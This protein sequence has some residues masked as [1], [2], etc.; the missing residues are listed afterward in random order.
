MDF[1]VPLAALWSMVCVTTRRP[2]L[3]LYAPFPWSGRRAFGFH[4]LLGAST[5][6]A[7][8]SYT[9]IHRPQSASQSESIALGPF[10][11]GYIS[12]L[13]YMC[14]DPVIPWADAQAL[15]HPPGPDCLIHLAWKVIIRLFR[16][17]S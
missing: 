6:T 17:L 12:V 14:S 9:L 16:R 7:I 15:S 5:G 11:V 4:L 3:M 2:W 8:F 1:L 10:S 13:G